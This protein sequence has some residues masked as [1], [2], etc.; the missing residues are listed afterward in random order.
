MI[1]VV[2]ASAG[3]EMLTDSAIGASI[4]KLLESAETTIAPELYISE[5][6]NIFWKATKRKELSLDQAITGLR[7]CISVVEFFKST[8]EIAVEALKEAELSGHS[9]YDLMYLITARR[10][11]A[12]I[13]T[14]DKGMQALAKKMKIRCFN[15]L[16]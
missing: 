6:T 5:V 16:R 10:E 8:A 13:V 15:F 2:D 12:S 14:V 7:L 3:F 4:R 1:V 9:A 11:S